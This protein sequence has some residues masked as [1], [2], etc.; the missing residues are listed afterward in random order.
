MKG[1]YSSFQII[2]RT[3]SRPAKGLDDTKDKREEEMKKRFV[4]VVILAVC[5]SMAL[6]TTG[7]SLKS[8]LSGKDKDEEETEEEEVSEVAITTDEA[9]EEAVTEEAETYDFSVEE[10]EEAVT[11]EVEEAEPETDEFG[12]TAMDEKK[13]YASEAVRIRREPSTDAEIAGKLSTGDEVTVNGKSDEWYRISKNDENLYVKAEYLTETK[14][15]KK[16]ET[17]D[18][19]NNAQSTDTSAQDTNKAAQDA[20]AAQ[21]LLEAAAQQQA[22][23]NQ[24]NAGAQTSDTQAAAA[25]QQ[26][27]AVQQAAV[28]PGAAAT[29][30]CTDGALTV[31]QKQ[32][33]VINKYWSYTGD[34]I[35]F[36]GHHSKGQLHELFAAEGVN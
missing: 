4:T 8:K 13:M 32:L 7:C 20:A 27:A 23:Q 36:A 2:R 10:E 18:N 12:I 34:A 35:G 24:Q 25:T 29:I 11:E 30:Q 14:A 21:K 15:E 16:E 33:D 17:T 19:N 31:N 28:S 1:P 22:A 6:L 5:M 26:A 3:D 9:T